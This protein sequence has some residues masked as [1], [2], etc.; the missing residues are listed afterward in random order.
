MESDIQCDFAENYSFV[1]Q[2]AAQSFHWN[3]DL[4]TLLTSVYYYIKEQELK[5]GSIV[6]ISDDL[7][8]DTATF[9]TFQKKLHQHLQEKEQNK[10]IHVT[11]G[12]PALQKQV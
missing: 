8:H 10:Y 1:V 5:H 6:M 2:D 4:A 7:Q 9:Y 3:N 12:A 11:D